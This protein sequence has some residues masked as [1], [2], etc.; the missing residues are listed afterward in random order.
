MIGDDRPALLPL[1]PDELPGPV[2]E[3]EEELPELLPVP[4]DTDEP[5]DTVPERKVPL[6]MFCSPVFV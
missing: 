4:A 6:T 1:E 5:P 2:A 3:P